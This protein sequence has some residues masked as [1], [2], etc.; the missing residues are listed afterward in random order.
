MSAPTS[1]SAPAEV[2]VAAAPA[3]PVEEGPKVRRDSPQ[4][5]AV[6]HAQVYVGNLAFSVCREP[7][8][9]TV[10]PS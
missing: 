10:R 1:E 9:E 5:S 7:P 8:L 2:P 6:A 4:R 3:A